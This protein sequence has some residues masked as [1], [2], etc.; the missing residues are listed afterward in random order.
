M[1]TIDY[2]FREKLN[3]VLGGF[4]HNYCYQCGA[5]VADCPAHRHLPEFN[6][7][8]II[9]NALFGFK[10]ELI[11]D[12]SIIWNCTNC[13]NCHE[14]CPQEVSPIEVII[15]LKN[16]CIEEGTNPPSVVNMV[17]RVKKS[18]FTVSLTEL[19]H[20]RREELGLPPFE[21]D[22]LEELQK[23]IKE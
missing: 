9:L 23:L 8:L 17:D 13:Y 5:C 14:R 4:S 7:R 18:G 15:A 11:G 16:M 1:K 10:E 19:S 12:N 2:S 20:K 6:P 3:K 22:C 21:S